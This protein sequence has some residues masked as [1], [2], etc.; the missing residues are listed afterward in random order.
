MH[1]VCQACQEQVP[2]LEV[3]RKFIHLFL[4]PKSPLPN[5]TAVRSIAH[6]KHELTPSAAA[7]C[8]WCWGHSIAFMEF[9]AVF[10]NTLTQYWKKKGGISENKEDLDPESAATT[11]TTSQ[12]PTVFAI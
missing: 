5:V 8:V 10:P 7:D 12:L 11:T 9:Q 3:C 1:S 6:L 4:P 2:V